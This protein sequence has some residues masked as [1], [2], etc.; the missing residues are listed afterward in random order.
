[1]PVPV[2]AAERTLD[3]LRALAKA[4]GPATASRL[5]ADLGIPRSSV[6]QLLRVM[7]DRGFVVHLAEEERWALGVAAFE[8]GSAFLRHDPLERVAQP[9]L[10]RLV[11]EARLP[12]VAHLGIVRGHETVYLLKEQSSQPMTVVTEVGVRLPASLTAS[13]RAYLSLLPRAQVRAQLSTP[14]AFV[15]RTGRG[16]RSLSALSTLLAEERRRG[17]TEEDGFITVGVASVAVPVI[18]QRGDPVASIGLTFRSDDVRP[19]RR[20]RLAAAAR[21][22]A[23]DLQARMRPRRALSP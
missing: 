2:P 7:G 12:V 9:L 15:D 5:A 13:G 4:A 23:E 1:M 8:V 22:C 21:R 19:E 11:E 14:D 6:Y 17:Y 20:P 10:R 16:P 3:L 18:D